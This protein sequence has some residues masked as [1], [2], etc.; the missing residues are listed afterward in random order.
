MEPELYRIAAEIAL[1]SLAPDMENAEK[2][3]ERALSV[4]R[5]RQMKSFELRAAMSMARLWRDQGKVREARKCWL[6][7]TGFQLPTFRRSRHEG[8]FSDF[9][10]PMNRL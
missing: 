2:H 8:G 1:K 3:F 5:Q 4:A 6:R 9:L 10:N 7:F